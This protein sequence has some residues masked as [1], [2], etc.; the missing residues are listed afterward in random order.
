MA[1]VMSR[2]LVALLALV[3]GA[4]SGSPTAPDPVQPG[5]PV[6]VNP[7]TVQETVVDSRPFRLDPCMSVCLV[8]TGHM[9][10]ALGKGRIRVSITLVEPEAR[11]E[12]ILWTDSS[13]SRTAIAR[14]FVTT[15]PDP[16]DPQLGSGSKGSVVFDEYDGQARYLSIVNASPIELH[17]GRQILHT[18]ER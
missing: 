18:P 2:A 14:Q 13:A 3:V 4:C 1:N 15:Q 11:L 9:L 7:P 6:V 5:P 12:V 10:P 16:S 8:G 17:G